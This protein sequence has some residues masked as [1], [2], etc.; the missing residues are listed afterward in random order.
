M[1]NILLDISFAGTAYAGWQR[2]KNGLA[3]QE[4]IENAITV[5][6]AE[7]IKLIGCSRT[8]AGVHAEQF[9]AN[10][11]TSSRIPA[12]RFQ[13]AI[14]SKL[15]KD[16]LIKRSREVAEAFNSRRDAAEKK[17]RYQIL[18][19]RSPILN[20]RWWQFPQDIAT[21]QLGELA[22]L[23]E[24]DHDFSGFCVRRSLRD[25][26]RCLISRANWRRQGRR[27]VFTIVGNRFLH[28]MVRF[29]VGAQIEVALGKLSIRDFENVILRPNDNR[30]LYPAPA[31][32]L[33]LS[34]VKY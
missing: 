28:R 23:I 32:G 30:A 27:L 17:Y 4:V 14:Q 19:G 6:T 18:L 5:L 15:P 11:K 2:Q 26:N 29:L 25:F 16:I 20:D 10:F 7:K 31:E 33:Y 21:D 22:S 34:R 24:G 1:R 13:P 9:F 3:I 12:E 8:D